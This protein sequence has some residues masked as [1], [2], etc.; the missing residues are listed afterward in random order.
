LEM[1]VSTRFGDTT[2]IHLVKQAGGARRQMTF[3]PDRV[4]R[5]SFPRHDTRYFVFAMD[6]GGDEF[7][8]LYRDD[9]ATGEVTLLTDGGRAQNRLGPWS[10]SGD[11]LAY[12][13]T[14]R[15]GADRDLYVIHPPA[16]QTDRPLAELSGGGW[17]PLDW[18]PDDRQLL[19]SEYLSINE[20]YLWL[21]DTTTGAKRALTPRSASDEAAYSGGAFSA[22]GKGVYVATDK[23]SEFMRL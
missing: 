4:T 8:Q 13:S 2:K 14:R 19:V 11:R 6:K 5:A 21:V 18:S 10:R 12:G 1:L 9:L 23:N 15:N 3:F 16:P 17:Q 20:S 7:A 22:D